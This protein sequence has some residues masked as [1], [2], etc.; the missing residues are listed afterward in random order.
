[1]FNASDVLRVETKLNGL[2]NYLNERM[3]IPKN[4]EATPNMAHIPKLFF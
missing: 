3:F 4:L 2:K 1:M